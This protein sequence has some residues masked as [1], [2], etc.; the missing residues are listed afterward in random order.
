MSCALQS[1][2][3]PAQGLPAH[4]NASSHDDNGLNLLKDPQRGPSLR[5]RPLNPRNNPRP[6]AANCKRFFIESTQVPGAGVRVSL[7]DLRTLSLGRGSFIWKRAAEACMVTGIPL[8]S[9]D[10][11]M[12]SLGD[13]LLGDMKI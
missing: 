6:L 9:S 5:R 4:Q 7:E 12:G 2:I 11:A 3:E 13:K 8:V 1:K 10:E